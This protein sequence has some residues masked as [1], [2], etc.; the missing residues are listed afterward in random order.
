[1]FVVWKVNGSRERNELILLAVVV[2][3]WIVISSMRGG[4]D[5][6]D[7]PRHRAIFL[8]WTALLA[9]W[10]WVWARKNRDSWLWRWAVVEAIF[11]LVFTEWY[12]SRYFQFIPRP[13]F[14]LMVI[15][16]V[17]LSFSF[18]VGSWI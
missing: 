14:Q 6:W 4:G 10:A 13:S 11:V 16:I 8:P 17:G 5:Q 7:N 12:L 9:G 1:M 15:V 18:M 3:A 2:W